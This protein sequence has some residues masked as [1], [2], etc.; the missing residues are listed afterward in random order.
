MH[1]HPDQLYRDLRSAE[2]IPAIVVIPIYVT[3]SL[4]LTGWDVS[5]QSTIIIDTRMLARSSSTY[6]YLTILRS[7]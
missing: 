1:W 7:I 6:F 3:V 2:V 5:D 4:R